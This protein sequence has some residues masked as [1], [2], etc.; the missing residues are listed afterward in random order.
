MTAEHHLYGDRG[1]YGPL[2]PIA[3]SPLHNG[4]YIAKHPDD[5]SKLVRSSGEG[6][7]YD[8]VEMDSR[9][10]ATQRV[11][12]GLAKLGL[13][14]ANPSY[15]DDTRQNEQPHLVTIVDRIT[16]HQPYADLVA[17]DDLSADQVDE[18]NNVIDIMLTYTGQVMNT[19][20][21]I[22][23]EMMRL[24]QFVYDASQPTGKKMVLVD[25][26]PVGG[27]KVDINEDSMAHG[28]PTFLMDTI[29]QLCTDAIE[30]SNKAGYPVTSLQKAAT[31]VGELPGN[32]AETN[33]AKATLLQ[34]LDTLSVDNEEMKEL[35]QSGLDW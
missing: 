6:A 23:S 29:V 32:S 25:V 1:F 33:E 22:D 21:Y 11:L 5:S 8:R 15:I 13:N 27:Q 31:I 30:L 9:V 28:Y 19:G 10:R 3:N 34:A 4:R 18:A 14:H 16:N 17:S 12:D 26:E 7:Y 24:D 35:I 20:D 2:E